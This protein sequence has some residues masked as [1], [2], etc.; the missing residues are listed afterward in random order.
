MKSIYII[1]A[2]LLIT[3]ATSA[4]QDASQNTTAN[5]SLNNKT[6]LS[7]FR[8]LQATNAIQ[9]SWTAL[10]ENNV[11]N[12]EIQKSANGSS[13]TTIGNLVAQ[14]NNTPYKYSFSDATRVAGINYYRLRTVEKSGH[15]T[16]SNILTV[17]NG[18]DR[19]GV[20]VFPNPIE[21]GVLNLQ[22]KNM[23]NG[24]YS[25]ALYSN[26]G[27]KVFARSLDFTEGS[28]TEII[29]LPGDLSRGTY[30]LQVTN[31]V[32]RINKQVLLQ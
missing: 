27:Q 17:N 32:T 11:S 21:G 23:S 19:T 10:N 8:A 31:G 12:H 20:M 6:V 16:Y 18:Y 26:G 9:L 29:N 30:F 25:I 13:F 7:D 28:A 1:L 24:K 14:N 4:Q 22:L 3:S 5:V 15:F 2:S